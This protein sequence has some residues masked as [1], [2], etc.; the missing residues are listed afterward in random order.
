MILFSIKVI[1]TGL[2]PNNSDLRS[3]DSA[4]T[5]GSIPKVLHF[6][7]QLALNKFD[8]ISEKAR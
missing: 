5:C 1:F 2:H 3:A 4:A 8:R 7:T 6:T